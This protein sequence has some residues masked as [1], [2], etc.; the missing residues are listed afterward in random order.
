MQLQ[1]APDVEV[2]TFLPRLKSVFRDGGSADGKPGLL[3]KPPFPPTCFR[4]NRPAHPQTADRFTL[5]LLAFPKT[6]ELFKILHKG[7]KIQL[8]VRSPLICLEAI[9]WPRY[10]PFSKQ[11]SDQLS[12]FSVSFF[13]LL[14]WPNILI[15]QIYFLLFLLHHKKNIFFF[16]IFFL[17]LF[18]SATKY[19]PLPSIFL[20]FLFL[21]C[22]VLRP[23]N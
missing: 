4:A 17:F 7:R 23:K 13:P 10:H 2:P 22:L 6:E 12:Y 16:Q 18:F 19:F 1:P 9:I 11:L 3:R 8:L 20:L 14:H 15:L 21:L 5:P